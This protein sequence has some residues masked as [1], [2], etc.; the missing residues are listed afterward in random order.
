MQKDRSTSLTR[1]PTKEIQDFEKKL[2][3]RKS[4]EDIVLQEVKNISCKGNIRV[5]STNYSNVSIVRL[6]NIFTYLAVVSRKSKKIK[7]VWWKSF[8]DVRLAAKA[9]DRKLLEKGLPAVNFNFKPVVI[10]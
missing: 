7:F 4:F 9:V 6:G 5:K 2:K 3:S 1:V 10:A 8:S